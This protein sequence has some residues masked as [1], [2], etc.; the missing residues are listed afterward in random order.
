MPIE[1]SRR[2]FLKLSAAV[3][4]MMSTPAYA[5]ALEWPPRAAD[6]GNFELF[7]GG[8]WV[9]MGD[10]VNAEVIRD[11]EEIDVTIAGDGWRRFAPVRHSETIYIVLVLAPGRD[12]ANLFHRDGVAMRTRVGDVWL[13]HAKLI[14]I[15]AEVGIG[16]P[17][18]PSSCS[19]EFRAIGDFMVTHGD[20]PP[21]VI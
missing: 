8:Q 9:K 21:A 13:S 5:A 12:P 20:E 7:Y 15:K 2:D 17:G 18:Y 1:T 3:A 14:P 4:I 19:F 16:K 10:L 6:V 11:I